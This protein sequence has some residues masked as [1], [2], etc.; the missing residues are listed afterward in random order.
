MSKILKPIIA[1][2]LSLS[3]IIG[4]ENAFSLPVLLSHIN[5]KSSEERGLEIAKE[6]DLRDAGFGDFTSKM[7]MI[8]RNR[9]GQESK[10]NIRLKTL[11]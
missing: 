4:M 7:V 8:L 5:E 10:R 9:H 6:A 1:A 2:S 3:L 11:V